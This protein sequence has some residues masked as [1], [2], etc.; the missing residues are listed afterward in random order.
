MPPNIIQKNQLFPEKTKP[1]LPPTKQVQYPVSNLNKIP[2]QINNQ[3]AN[4]QYNFTQEA[5]EMVKKI[6]NDKSEQTQQILLEP[7]CKQDV[8]G[9]TEVTGFKR[10]DNM[11]KNKFPTKLELVNELYVYVSK[12]DEEGLKQFTDN[13]NSTILDIERDMN[14]L[15]LLKNDYREI[16]EKIKQT[17]TQ[18]IK[19]IDFEYSDI[20]I[21]DNIEYERKDTKSKD[22][23]QYTIM[24]QTVPK[25]NKKN[26]DETYSQLSLPIKTQQQQNK[27]L[28]IRYQHN[29]PT[30]NGE[31]IGTRI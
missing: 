3:T 21:L 27:V 26:I 10:I 20:M 24:M 2:I 18:I 4:N 1:I 30:S 25:K 11:I 23:F 19:Y 22:I 16:I 28:L 5:T 8:F 12:N 6:V 31:I 29:Q 14:K 9:R 13:L 15:N 7:I 17:N